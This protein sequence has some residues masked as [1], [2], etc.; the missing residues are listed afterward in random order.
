VADLLWWIVA[1]GA[2]ALP[3]RV[4]PRLPP[5][6][7]I[8]SAAGASGLLQA[9]GGFALG[10]RGFFAFA[11]RT[12]DLNNAWMLQRLAAPAV[13]GDEA[14]AFV[15]Y[16]VSVLTLFLFLFLT[17]AGLFSLY[18][19]AVGSVRAIGAWFDDPLG[20]AILS[21]V[22]WAA[23]T[24]LAGKRRKRQERSREE[25]EGAA[26]PDVLR[27]GAW[28]GLDVDYVVLASR[29]KPEWDAGAVILAG[30]ES[31][32]LGVPFDKDTPAG[33]RTVYP[34]KREETLEALRRA[35]RYELPPLPGSKA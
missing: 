14:V 26:A 31:Y 20:D 1:L 10:V 11:E 6:L 24:A 29:R 27:T 34:L 21:G 2:A 16:G 25:R 4:W 17:P 23:T 13:R 15:P 3:R 8:H 33:L 28:A 35:I 7:P 32:R 12:A 9:A 5:R 30:D 22:H 18:L 19:M